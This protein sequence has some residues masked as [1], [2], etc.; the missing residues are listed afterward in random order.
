MHNPIYWTVSVYFKEQTSKC[1]LVH[2]VQ[3]DYNTWWI[4][5]PLFPANCLSTMAV[6][7]N[8][9]KISA[10]GRQ[11]I[12]PKLAAVGGDHSH[13]GTDHDPLLWTEAGVLGEWRT[14]TLLTFVLIEQI[15]QKFHQVRVYVFFSWFIIKYNDIWKDIGFINSLWINAHVQFES[16]D[17]YLRLL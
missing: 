12:C 3:H 9:L 14:L 4:Q 5:V 13:Y 8:E 11:L 2:V 1:L 15:V 6:A 7:Y 16:T 17:Y 10:L